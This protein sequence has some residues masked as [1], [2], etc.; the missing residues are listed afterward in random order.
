FEGIKGVSAWFMTDEEIEKY[1]GKRQKKALK[2]KKEKGWWAAEKEYFMSDPIMQTILNLFSK[3][4]EN[5][6]VEIEVKNPEA[7]NNIKVN[8]KYIGTGNIST[9]NIGDRK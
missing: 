8:G 9:A 3:E 2:T 1:G 4:K 7:V 6:K 5:I